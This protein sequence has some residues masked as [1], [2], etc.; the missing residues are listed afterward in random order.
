MT[1]CIK[2]IYGLKMCVNI[3]GWK[4][5]YTV[6]NVFSAVLHVMFVLFFNNLTLPRS[7]S[8]RK[9]EPKWILRGWY[10]KVVLCFDKQWSLFISILVFILWLMENVYCTVKYTLSYIFKLSIL[11]ASTVISWR[12]CALLSVLTYYRLWYRNFGSETRSR[13]YQRLNVGAQ[14]NMRVHTDQSQ[15]KRP[16]PFRS[17]LFPW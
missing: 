17:I 13:L 11:K 7:G 3:R 4:D 8:L 1:L 6:C 10:C 15:L 14:T 2:N 12:L 9:L 16:L 5:K